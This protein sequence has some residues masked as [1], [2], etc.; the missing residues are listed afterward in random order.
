MHIL[1]EN[2]KSP[3]PIATAQIIY[4]LQKRLKVYAER[5]SV[6]QSN[7]LI[8]CFRIHFL[9]FFLKYNVFNLKLLEDIFIIR[10]ADQR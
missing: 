4:K 1:N 10:K 9:I 2:I 6:A 7:N 8:I 5:L 3:A